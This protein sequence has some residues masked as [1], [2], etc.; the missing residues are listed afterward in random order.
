MFPD[1]RSEDDSVTGNARRSLRVARSKADRKAEPLLVNAYYVPPMLSGEN[2]MRRV[3]GVIIIVIMV[4]LAA[5]LRDV[6]AEGEGSAVF[7]ETALGKPDVDIMVV[8]SGLYKIQQSLSGFVARTEA[9]L[10]LL[11]EYGIYK[12]NGISLG[13][14]IGEEVSVTGIIRDD[15]ELRSIYVVRVDGK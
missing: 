13:E 8:Q 6:A 11:T 12:L 4:W 5:S 2:A 9:G 1:K 10:A 14:R 15:N 3:S 7:V